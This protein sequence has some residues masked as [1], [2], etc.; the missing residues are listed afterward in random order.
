MKN[1]LYSVGTNILGQC[2]LPLSQRRYTRF[3]KISLPTHD[4]PNIV[5]SGIFNR[6]S[7]ITIISNSNENR[8]LCCGDNSCGQ[9]G[10]SDKTSEYD[11]ITLINIQNNLSS[12]NIK[13]I[14]CSDQHSLFLCKDGRLFS[15]GDNEYGTAGLSEN[16][17]ETLMPTQII[18]N[19]CIIDIDCGMW[20]NICVDISHKVWVFGANFF[21]QIGLQNIDDRY[22]CFEPKINTFFKGK[23]IHRIECGSTHSLCVSLDGNVYLCGQASMGQIGNGIGSCDSVFMPYCLRSNEK[24]Q[25]MIV[26]DVSC[27]A[28]HNVLLTAE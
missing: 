16:I 27:G 11:R 23:G 15:C 5:S 7:F 9:F 18:K 12:N 2:A 14:V 8:L 1:E 28:N 21:G 25:N 22:L 17:S 20:H 26:T 10:N 24:F 6:H 19:E 13:K 4:I 3:Q